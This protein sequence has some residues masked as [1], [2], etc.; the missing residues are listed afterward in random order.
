MSQTL[1]DIEIIVVDNNSQDGS[2]AILDDYPRVSIIRNMA[3]LGFAAGQNQGFRLARGQYIMA[4]NYDLYM[5]PQFLESLLIGLK[6][7]NQAGWACGKLLNMSPDGKMEKTIYAVGHTLPLNRFPKLRG[8]GDVDCGQYDQREYVFGAPGAAVIYR[9]EFIDH[10]S[11]DDQF[12]DESFFTWYED[13]DV[14]WRG[15]NCGWKCIYIPDAQAYHQ[16]HV[17]ERYVDP[18]LS[19]FVELTVRNRW[20]MVLAN[21]LELKHNFSL[22]I[23]QYEF[24]L[25]RY[26][27][28]ER[29]LKAYVRAIYGVYTRV[30]LIQHKRK[31]ILKKS[32]EKGCF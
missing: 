15:N 11:F 1:Q 25:L 32:L 26:V 21:E 28:R 9:R 6:S 31:S 3:N 17:G 18:F 23:M 7:D 19:F 13:V 4:L 8:N 10:I 12:F 27:L 22:S 2:L 30:A 24:A 14:D 29:L 5:P 20:L 16:G